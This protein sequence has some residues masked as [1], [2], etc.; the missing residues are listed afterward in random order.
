MI[1]A[2][3]CNIQS[4]EDNV[5]VAVTIRDDTINGKE[6]LAFSARLILGAF[7]TITSVLSQHVLRQRCNIQ[8]NGYD[9]SFQPVD[10]PHSAANYYITFTTQKYEPG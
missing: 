3:L 2:Y 10:R 7:P 8:T 6:R 5:N 1:N 4:L 9:F